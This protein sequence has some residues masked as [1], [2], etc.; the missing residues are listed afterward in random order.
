MDQLYEKAGESTQAGLLLSMTEAVDNTLVDQIPS[1]VVGQMV[2][3][4]SEAAAHA[5]DLPAQRRA[6]VSGLAELVGGD[7]WIWTTSQARPETGEVAGLSVVSGG[8]KSDDELGKL[9]ELH[10][11]PVGLRAVKTFAKARKH[12]T[13]LRADFADDEE[14]QSTRWYRESAFDDCV[15]SIY[16]TVPPAMSCV[17]IHRQKG[18]PRFTGLESTIVHLVLSQVSWMHY[19]LENAQLADTTLGLTPR[20][21][22]VLVQ[23][24]CGRSTRDI[25]SALGISIHTVHD[26]VKAVLEAFKVKTRTELLARYLSGQVSTRLGD[27]GAKRVDPSGTP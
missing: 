20:Q 8:W 13:L 21:R 17:G 26:H 1:S 25:A 5:G 9:V 4:V 14:F 15:L 24:I 27:D 23:L 16:P 18:R 22:H 19:G 2:R 10:D 7:L 12:T 6:L 11:S 3:L